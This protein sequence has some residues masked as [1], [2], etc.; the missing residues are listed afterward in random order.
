M[1]ARSYIRYGVIVVV[2]LALIAGARLL[3]LREPVDA[4]KSSVAGLGI[5]G[6]IVFAM[7]YALATVLMLP[8][9]L[10]TLA[11][12]AA[13]GLARGFATV[14]VGATLGAALAFLVSRHFAR[15]RVESWI[16]GKPSFAVID[17]A[18]AKEGWK[19]VFLTRL[20]PAFPFNFQNYAYGLTS[21]PFWQYALASALGMLP[22]TFL[23]VYLGFAGTSSLEGRGALKLVQ[24]FLGLF[25][26]LAATVLIT[27]T[28]KR[29][30]REAG[31]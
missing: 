12:G 25:A 30:L 14:W 17:K 23:Y 13:F 10:L 8:G 15:R 22:G 21:V 9:S 4:F 6:M 3:P 11:G 19:I 31:V 29:A 18:V 5:A 24:L 26:T 16:Q 2:L 28:A 27:R 1:A 20:S 7:A